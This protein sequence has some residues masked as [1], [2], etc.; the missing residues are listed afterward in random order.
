M[1]ETIKREVIGLLSS[2][3]IQA[4]SDVEMVEA[5]RREATKVPLQFQHAAPDS[6]NQTQSSE[7]KMQGA[8]AA[9]SPVRE[10]AKVGR[11]AYCPCGS[12]KKYKHCHG[13]L[14]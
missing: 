12:G 1:L 11:N 7:P 10:A 13:Q 2:V 8:G 4:P 14:A 3:D 6:M 9:T 5:Q